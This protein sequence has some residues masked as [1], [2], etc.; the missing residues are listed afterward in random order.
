MENGH[1][2]FLMVAA[3]ALRARLS[4]RWCGA[5]CVWL[6]L[7]PCTQQAS[8]DPKLFFRHPCQKDQ[9]SARLGPSIDINNSAMR[10]LPIGLRCPS[11]A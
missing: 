1:G 9:L 8:F 3:S 11:K 5:L 6:Q 10:L 7:G 2:Q 4:V